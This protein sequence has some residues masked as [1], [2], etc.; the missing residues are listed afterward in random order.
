MAEN[1]EKILRMQTDYPGKDTTVAF[2]KYTQSAALK[3]FIPLLTTHLPHSNALYNRMQAHHNTPGRQC[4]YAG[5][6]PPAASP[7]DIY[8]IVFADRS[9]HS[10][11]QIWVF[12]PLICLRPLGDLSAP[13]GLSEFQREVLMRHVRSLL[14][15]LRDTEIPNAPGWP[16]SPVLRFG[17]LHS[18]LSE[19]LE[20]FAP[21]VRVSRWHQYLIPVTLSAQ[22]G[23]KKSAEVVQNVARNPEN[24]IS[25]PVPDDQLAVVIATSY[26]PRQPSTLRMLPN[27]GLLDK[28]GKLVAW[29]YLGIEG[30]LATLYVLPEYR[31]KGV[32]NYI[33]GELLKKLGNGNF[34]HMGYQSPWVH[35]EIAEEN[36]ASIGVA[37]KLGGKLAWE[38][39]YVWVD[40]D[41]L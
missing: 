41:K 8:T 3:T 22:T 37:L 4:L 2:H 27:E 1:G 25:G 14:Y 34:K 12:N 35:A 7:P 32:A 5:S 11:S 26:I 9:R 23:D 17:T 24:L 16:F 20:R 30:A 39:R 19:C 13:S 18:T 31:G 6:F 33:A 28:T 29:A 10:E 21:I 40:S 15:F 36:K 38:S